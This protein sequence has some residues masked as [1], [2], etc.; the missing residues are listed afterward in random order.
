M[1][2]EAMPSVIFRT[3][4]FDVCKKIVTARTGT[5]EFYY[6]KKPNAVSIA[7]F[8][9]NRILL[10][11]AHRAT[12]GISAY[13]LP[14]GRIEPGEAPEDAVIRELYEEAGARIDAPQMLHVIS[15]LTA[16][17][18]ELIHIFAGR[19]TGNAKVL[20]SARAEG[21]EELEFFSE[22]EALDLIYENKIAMSADV[23]AIV[24]A[25]KWLSSHQGDI[26]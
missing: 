25:F 19:M 12:T 9:D 1:S 2:K 17:S 13:E 3:P 14:G 8:E 10:L 22:T 6:I 23:H 26:G 5:R 4:R 11:K 18:T 21:I 7:A 20:D 16:T 24:L 15:P